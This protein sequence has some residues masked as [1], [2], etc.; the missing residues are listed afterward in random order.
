MST[1]PLPTAPLRRTPLYDE[2][3]KLGGR[4]VPFAG[5]EMPVQYKGVTEEHRA[6]RTAAGLFDVSHMGEIILSGEHA[7]QV[8][9]YLV[10]ND[11]K[12]L[13]DGHALY[14]CACN[15]AGT[16]LD[17]LIVY[18]IDARQWLIV[19][20]ASNRDKI[21]AHFRSA[22]QG[23]C[24]FEDASDRTAMMALQ[25]PK[26]LDIAA[27]AGG[28]GAALRELPAF[29][30]RDA[31]LAG[32]RCTVARTGYTGEDGIEVFC[33]PS[34]AQRLWRALVE[35]GSPL[36]LEATG[37]G[38]RD[39]LRLEARLSLY[40]N[41]IDETTNPI[42]AGLGWVVKLDKGDFVGRAALQR[43]K[44]EGP[45]RKLIGFE[46]VGRGIARHGYPLL[47]ADGAKVGVCT[48][49]SPGPTVGKNIGLGYLPVSMAAVGTP[50]QVDCRGRSVEAV[51][52]KT[53]FYKRA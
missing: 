4:M 41:D 14:T 39:T 52:V 6:V 11:V 24:S 15:D 47:D 13:E 1:K 20:N 16:I 36:G 8:V 33:S 51:V 10:T 7:G 28:D 53:P 5:W 40:G 38:A 30:F 18:R 3:I 34:D 35:L 17:D 50:F 29:H 26:A 25:G 31:T 32:V 12:K 44:A 22:A 37:L 49:G 42:E 27:L 23:H 46:M 2:H 48:S 19:C 43:V 45:T 21:A 9:D